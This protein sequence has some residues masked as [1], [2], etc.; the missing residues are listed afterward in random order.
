MKNII[1]SKKVITFTACFCAAIVFYYF[2]SLNG[3]LKAS[4]SKII[5][6]SKGMSV[7][8]FQ[9]K[10]ANKN[11]IVLVY[12]HASWCVPCI[13]L[14]P[15]ITQLESEA[16]NYCE[17]LKIDTDENPLIADYYEINSL[18]MFVIYKNGLKSWENIGA[19]SKTQ[20]EEKLNIFK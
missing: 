18:P 20:I 15:E 19:L 1:L 3:E 17:V 14:K 6:Q 4:N 2:I 9:K 11:K 7:E 5:F 10:I 13:K 12:F 16:M 8:E